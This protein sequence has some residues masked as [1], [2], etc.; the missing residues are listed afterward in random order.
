MSDKDVVFTMIYRED[1]DWIN[2]TKGKLNREEKLH[3]IIENAKKIQLA[4]TYEDDGAHITADAIRRK[5][6]A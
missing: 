6:V 5:L 3:E 2:N 1:R 4:Q